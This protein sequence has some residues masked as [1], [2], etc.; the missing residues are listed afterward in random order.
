MEKLKKYVA[1]KKKSQY[2]WKNCKNKN[3]VNSYHDYGIRIKDLSKK[4]NVLAF[5]E[6]KIVECFENQSKNILGIM[7]HPERYLHVRNFDK[8]LIR[9]ILD[10]INCFSSR[11]WI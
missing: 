3:K 7:W 2:L 4:F 6:D 8:K 5:T 1:R 11:S 10:A 9:K